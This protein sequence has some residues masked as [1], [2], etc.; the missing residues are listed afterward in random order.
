MQPFFV[1]GH[2]VAHSKS[3]VMHNA[4]YRALGLPWEYG[5]ADCAT[6]SEA[7]AFLASDS[8][9]GLNVTTPYKPLALEVATQCTTAAVIAQGANVLVRCGGGEDGELLADNTD[10]AGCVAFLQHS[11]I[12][13]EGAR[14]VVCGTGPTSLSIAHALAQASVCEVTLLGRNAE[15]SRHALAG[16][17]ERCERASVALGASLS[18]GDYES[19]ASSIEQADLIVDATP[20]GMRPG[21]P[22][23]FDTSLLAANQ[24]VLD[25]VYGHGETALLAA[26]RAADCT[27]FDGFGMLVGQAVQ[28]VRDF[29]TWLH[30][31]LENSDVDLFAIMSDAASNPLGSGQMA[32]PTR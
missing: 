16:M 17:L 24:V 4:A 30:A 13:L 2:P 29:T 1:L 15:R 8:W 7:R 22:A 21:D 23:P 6:E 25:V 19:G 18:A 14:A 12:A 31:P 10:G 28:T 27:A 26:A 3:P 9:L 5:L 32:R 20:L 11:S